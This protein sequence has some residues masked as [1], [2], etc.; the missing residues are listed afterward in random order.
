MFSSDVAK[1]ELG[2]S[3]SWAR[4]LFGLQAQTYLQH[5]QCII[6]PDLLD[7]INYL[8]QTQVVQYRLSILKFSFESECKQFLKQTEASPDKIKHHYILY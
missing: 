6:G 3:M 1:W 7:E 2:G 5:A 4:F 8:R